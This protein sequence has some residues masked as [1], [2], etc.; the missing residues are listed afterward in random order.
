[1]VALLGYLFIGTLANHGVSEKREQIP[2]KIW[3]QV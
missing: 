3:T 1:M 2:G